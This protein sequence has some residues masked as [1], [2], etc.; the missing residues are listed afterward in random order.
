MIAWTR[1]AHH[2]QGFVEVGGETRDE[3]VF[4]SEFL[5]RAAADGID[6]VESRQLVVRRIRLGHLFDVIHDELVEL[7]LASFA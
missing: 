3:D 1:V 7:L 2:L 5:Q 6:Q 4:A